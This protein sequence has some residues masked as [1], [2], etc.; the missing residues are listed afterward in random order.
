MLFE[1]LIDGW[2]GGRPHSNIMSLEARGAVAKNVKDF[3]Y[4]GRVKNLKIIRYF[5]RTS[6][7]ASSSFII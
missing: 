4:G 6:L 5:F 7:A 3:S 1:K 2:G